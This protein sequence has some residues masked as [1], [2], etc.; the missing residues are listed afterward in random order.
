MKYEKKGFLARIVRTNLT[1]EHFTT[2]ADGS[3]NMGEGYCD[4]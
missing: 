2:G 3:Q 4:F 1:E